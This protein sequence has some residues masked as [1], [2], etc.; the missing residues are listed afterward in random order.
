MYGIIRL[1]DDRGWY[2]FLRRYGR[3]YSAVFTDRGHGGRKR[4][5]AAAK[6][7]RDRLVRE[8]NPMTKREFAMIRRSTN[9]SGIPGVRRIEKA[10][11]YAYWTATTELPTGR[12]HRTFSVNLLGEE[13]ARQR[14]I[15]E[16]E[17]QL[18]SVTGH[19]LFSP[20]ATASR[21]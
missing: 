14:A 9:T 2:V 12:L 7:H 21:R 19:R 16:R 11:G 1:P 10:S 8:L 18:E 15:E 13:V 3:R 4:A 6:A 17:R 20:A 5:L